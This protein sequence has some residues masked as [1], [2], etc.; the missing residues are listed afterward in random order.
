MCYPSLRER[1][2]KKKKKV[3]DS[4]CPFAGRVPFHR[5]LFI[6]SKNE[7]TFSKKTEGKKRGMD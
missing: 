3:H 5:V 1:R 6:I 7:F 2:K 4:P